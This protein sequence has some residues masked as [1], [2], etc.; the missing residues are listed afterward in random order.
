MTR[1]IVHVSGVDPGQETGMGR[2]SWHWRE[3]CKQR[4]WAFIHI[5]PTTT[6]RVQHPALFPR[7]AWRAF[8]RLH[9]RADLFLVHEP[10][11]ASFVGHGTPTVVFSH[12]LERRRW[13][14][15]RQ[16]AADWS[17]PVRLRTHIL[18]P[19]WRL[20][21][22]DVG[23]RRAD[24]VML[25]NEEDSRYAARRYRLSPERRWVFQNGV[26][27]TEG[28]ADD[29]DDR[30]APRRF[31]ALFL[32]SW[33]T[34]KGVRT[35]A[36]AAAGLQRAGV[37]TEWTLAGVGRS[38]RE[39][40]SEWP[41]ELA[42]STTVIPSFAARDE[43]QLIRGS[44]VLVLPSFFEGQPLSVL[45]AMEAGRCCITTDCCGQRDFIRHRDNGL[46]HAPGDAGALVALLEECARNEIFRREVGRRAK[47]SMRDRAWP[48]V[49]ARV[50][51]QLDSVIRSGA[52]LR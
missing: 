20:R 15:S 25:I 24:A 46:L 2:V 18:F 49:A 51:E 22:S 47:Q 38:A 11:A 32:G 27:P 13:E 33:I 35:L 52:W 45:Q 8:Q 23:L 39:V 14:L 21:P 41:P 42:G 19:L 5:G 3:A 34:R 50:A 43:A 30:P 16:G 4:G 10:I 28:G 12:G 31:R 48:D 1:V 9:Q 7:A 37:E 29:A 26:Y 17:D 44:D 36:R 40:L 6:N